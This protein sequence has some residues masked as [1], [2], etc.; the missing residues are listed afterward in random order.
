MYRG[1]GKAIDLQKVETNDAVEALAEAL[2]KQ[3]LTIMAI[4]P[5]TNVGLLLLKYP[6]LKAQIEEVVLVA[7]RRKPTDYFSIGNQGS[8]AR[9]LN[10]DLDNDAFRLMFE[11]E[12]PV[13][14]CPFEISSKVW[15]KEADLDQ[16]AQGNAGNRWLAYASKAWLQQWVEQGADGFN[17][18]ERAGQP[19]HSRSRGYYFRAT[20][21][22][23]GNS[24]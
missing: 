2:R 9:D 17:P 14:L 12:V 11:H 16:L 1:A 10:F 5:A 3:T 15:L 20:E 24:P 18:F 4:G 23:S 8:R 13:T 6:E 22:P 19:L 21:R 7:G